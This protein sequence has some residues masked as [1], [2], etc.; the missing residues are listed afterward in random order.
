MM[1]LSPETI[2]LPC[3]YLVCSLLEF[4]TQWIFLFSYVGNLLNQQ[5]IPGSSKFH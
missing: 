4:A 5:Q 2:H 3:G 1:V